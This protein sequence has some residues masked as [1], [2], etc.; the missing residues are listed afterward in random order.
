M[1]LV[2]LSSLRWDDA[3]HQAESFE[4][5]L[6]EPFTANPSAGGDATS[7][8]RRPRWVPVVLGASAGQEDVVVGALRRHGDV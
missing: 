7:A 1:V 6:Q 5:F 3:I 2:N 8:T 4:V